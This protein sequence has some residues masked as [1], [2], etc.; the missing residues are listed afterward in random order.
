MET[1]EERVT[2][3]YVLCPLCKSKLKLLGRHLKDKHSLS[4][5]ELRKDY[6]GYPANCLSVTKAR[7]KQM[8]HLNKKQDLFYLIN[9]YLFF[10]DNNRIIK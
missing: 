1:M 2:K 4:I 3:D 5:F 9:L 8:K 7:S 6:P 10:K